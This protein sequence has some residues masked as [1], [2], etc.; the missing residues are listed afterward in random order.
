M[1]MLRS[2]CPPN[3]VLVRQ[4]SAWNNERMCTMIVRRI[5]LVLR[6]HMGTLQPVLLLDAVRL[7]ITRMV[8]AACS[9]VGLW[10][11]VVPA[12]MTWLLQPL[13]SHAFLAY[14]AHLKAKYQ[15]KRAELGSSDLGI[16]HFLECVYEAIRHVL[17]GR[18][19][20]VAFEG[21]G[22]G[23][24][25]QGLSTFVQK[26]LA[27]AGP[28]SITALRPNIEELGHCFPRRAQVHAD[29]LYRPFG[30]LAAAKVAPRPVLPMRSAL[31]KPLPRLGRTRA[32]HREALCAEEATVEAVAVSGSKT[33]VGVA[34]AIR[35]PRGRAT[36]VESAC[37]A[38]SVSASRQ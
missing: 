4:N 30:F 16:E 7:H 17:Q 29:L 18:C 38:E 14:K 1:A 27:I 37:V 35:L 20:N 22:F 12:K 2:R 19:W 9:A 21:D 34:R 13:D 6:A 28:L 36:A 5:A 23:S 15:S 3:V 11:V 31:A 24:A 10:V 8:L 25:Q 33:A 26:Q 32:Q